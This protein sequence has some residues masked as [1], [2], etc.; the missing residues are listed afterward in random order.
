[1]AA[2]PEEDFKQD[3]NAVVEDLRKNSKDLKRL[4][5]D[6][7][8]YAS[9]IVNRSSVGSNLLLRYG[10]NQQQ[11]LDAIGKEL[12][13]KL[14]EQNEQIAK[15]AIVA[16]N[17]EVT[18]GFEIG[19]D[20]RIDAIVQGIKKDM[21]KQLESLGGLKAVGDTHGNRV[22]VNETYHQQL[23]IVCRNSS[24]WHKFEEETK[25]FTHGNTEILYQAVTQKLCPGIVNMFS[26]DGN[27]VGDSTGEGRSE[28]VTGFTVE[29]LAKWYESK[30]KE[31]S[32]MPAPAP[33]APAPAPAT[34][35]I[36]PAPKS[37]DKQG[38]NSLHTQQQLHKSQQPSLAALASKSAQATKSESIQ[39][40][41]KP[42]DDKSK[43]D[44]KGD[45][46]LM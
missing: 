9:L 34:F 19:F 2:N 39:P 6:Y 40:A 45:C 37:T 15:T 33:A 7:D 27:Y 23:E 25:S 28:S 20:E 35:S 41:P 29:E 18:T 42:T 44:K 11:F 36:Q 38:E 10:L 21:E 5:T 12:K 8:T 13:N 30:R 46:S 4:C 3:V 17:S 43:K 14:R 1:M 24:Q 16:S 32:V 22:R 26:S 31:T